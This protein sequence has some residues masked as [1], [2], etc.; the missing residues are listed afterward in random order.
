MTDNRKSIRVTIPATDRA[1]FEQAKAKAENAAMIRLTDT[2]YASRLI[3]WALKMQDSAYVLLRTDGDDMTLSVH[4]QHGTAAHN[5][6]C[7][8][9]YLYECHIDRE[10]PEQLIKGDTNGKISV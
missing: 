5:S 7:N 4:G 2:Q 1:K 6:A 3:Q 8:M 9:A 10:E